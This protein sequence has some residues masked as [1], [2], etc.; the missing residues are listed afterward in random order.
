MQVVFDSKPLAPAKRRQA[1]RDAICDIY[2][3]VDC[4]GEDN[5]DYE[6]FVREARFGAVTLTDTLISPQTVR[7]QNHHV[8]R[9][10]KDCYYIGIEHINAVNIRQAGASLIL[11]PG[12]G[13]IYYAN[14]PYELECNRTSRQFW[15]ELPRDD[16]DR[17]FDLGRPP[18]LSQ[19]DLSRGLG[20]IAADFCASL[21]AESAAI[22]PYARV[23]LG[24]QLMDIMALALS[25]DA[26]RHSAD[27]SSVQRARLRS[28]KAHME[29]NLGDPNLS[30][31]AVAR[32]NGVSTR[33]LHQLFRLTGMTASDWL[34]LRRLQRCYDLLT[35]PQH[36]NLSITDIAFSM[37]FSSS[38][39]FSNLFRAQFK[40]RPSD[41]RAAATSS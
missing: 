30:L 13:G 40:V 6:G 26:N 21:A 41:I 10:D 4:A 16:F 8:A 7:R 5:S 20:R 38:S 35:S 15:I 23:R 39:H 9:S 28:I 37:G 12:Y 17:R 31:T 3:Q 33:Y 24:Q 2:L 36:L 29:A 25:G 27:E 22:D 14:Q 34:R 1:W 19:F 18:V 11:R 32:K